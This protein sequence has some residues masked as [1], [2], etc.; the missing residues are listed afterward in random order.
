LYLHFTAL[1]VLWTPNH[2]SKVVW[3]MLDT[4]V[5]SYDAY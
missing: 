4:S 5:C 2:L 1:L 3:Q